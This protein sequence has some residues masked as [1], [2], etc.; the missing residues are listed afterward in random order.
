LRRRY[1]AGR[2]LG[3]SEYVAAVEPVIR[4]LRVVGALQQPKLAAE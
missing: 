4:A 1:R 2:D 3:L